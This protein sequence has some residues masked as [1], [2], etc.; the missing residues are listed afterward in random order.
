MK[1]ILL[2]ILF[3]LAL[4]IGGGSAGFA[5]FVDDE[6][7]GDPDYNIATSEESKPEKGGFCP[8]TYHDKS[9]FVCHSAPSNELKEPDP[10]SVYDYPGI[11]TH[12]YKDKGDNLYAHFYMTTVDSD[13]THEF[14]EYVY[15]HP[16][17][18]RVV[19]DIHSSG[20]SVAEAWRIVSQM[21]V[22][23]NRGLT[24]ETNV[25]G[26]GASA[27]FLILVNGSK[28]HR[29]VSQRAMLLHHEIWTLSWIKIETPSSAEETARVMR[30]WQDNISEW[31]AERSKLTKKQLTDMVENAEFW[32][33]G[34]Q[35][36][37][38][39]GFADGF[40]E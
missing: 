19:L 29:L 15:E 26:F 31:L 12:F 5:G 20:G 3:I 16:A 40:I 13:K 34:I 1:N 11:E 39:Y 22:A 7:P 21:N 32:M 28:K 24:V 9:C 2:T 35:A 4:A 30:F 25:K 6:A 10:H 36:Y 27:A 38:K 18:K 37:K 33:N 14:F 17:I 8:I 23:K